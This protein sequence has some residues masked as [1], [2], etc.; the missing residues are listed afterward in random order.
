MKC[1]KTN[2]TN[3]KRCS[4]TAKHGYCWQHKP[5]IHKITDLQ[6]QIQNE[7]KKIEINS[8]ID[9][10]YLTTIKPYN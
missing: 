5:A 8:R 9:R 2:N 7:S 6:T 4:R 10:H 3:N 1:Y